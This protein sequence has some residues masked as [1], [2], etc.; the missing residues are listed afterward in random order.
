[1][2]VSIKKMGGLLLISLFAVGIP[3]SIQQWPVWTQKEMIKTEVA[4]VLR[5]TKSLG[6]FVLN[7]TLGTPFSSESLLGHWTMMFFGYAQCPKICPQALTLVSE[8]WRSFPG[9]KPHSSAQFVFVTLNPAVDTVEALKPFVQQFHPEFIGLTGNKT[10][11]MRLSKASGVY[12][13][14]EPS[15]EMS[16][17]PKVIDHSATILLLGPDGRL[18]ALFSPPHDG[19]AIARDL[20]KIIHQ[21]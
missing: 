16:S 15:E 14:T 8:V 19:L 7:S 20:Q 2:P 3:W 6:N 21:R 18:Q 9:E 10:D 1:M 12:S 11:I 4:T 17:K 13:W 5:P